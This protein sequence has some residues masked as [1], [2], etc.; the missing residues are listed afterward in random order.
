MIMT[1]FQAKLLRRGLSPSGIIRLS[2]DVSFA[3]SEAAT[4]RELAAQGLVRRG[5]PAKNPARPGS[6]FLTER[7]RHCTCKH[8][9][10]NENLADRY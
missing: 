9:G 5:S 1:D 6:W 3:M 4:L 8:G 10:Y 2:A 7:G